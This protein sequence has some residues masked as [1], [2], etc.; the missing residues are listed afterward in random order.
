MGDGTWTETDRSSEIIDTARLLGIDA[1]IVGG[2]AQLVAQYVQEHTGK[3][4]R[5]VTLGHLQRGGRP[6][7][8]DRLLALRFGAAAVRAVEQGRVGH[9]V[10]FDPPDVTTLPMTETSAEPKRVPL[11]CDQIMTARDL[12]ICMGD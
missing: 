4:T 5:T 12:A 6:T 7:T 8:F 9:M 3:E 2:V 1:L 10:A 11:D